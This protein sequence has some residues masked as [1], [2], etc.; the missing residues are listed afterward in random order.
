V[1]RAARPDPLQQLKSL[2]LDAVSSPLTK[3]QYE[4]AL[5]RFIGRPFRLRHDEAVRPSAEGNRPESD[6]K[7]SGWAYF[8]AYHSKNGFGRL[9]RS[10]L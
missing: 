7:G 8:W 3:R 5:D 6:G 9:T 10:R 1:I 4:I 2:V